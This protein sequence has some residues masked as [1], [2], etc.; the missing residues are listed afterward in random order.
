MSLGREWT[1]VFVS[2]ETIF[3]KTIKKIKWAKVTKIRHL[4][5]STFSAYVDY[6]GIKVLKEDSV[7][8]AWGRVKYWKNKQTCHKPAT[9]K[10]GYL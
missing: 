9:M 8:N 7:H 4:I 3:N 1:F 6:D 5:I 2:V 10:P